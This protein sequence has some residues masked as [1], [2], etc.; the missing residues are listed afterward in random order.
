MSNELDVSCREKPASKLNK[1]DLI[2]LSYVLVK[3]SEGLETTFNA[4]VIGAT[5]YSEIIWIV[6]V[7]QSDITSSAMD[8]M[9]NKYG[10]INCFEKWHWYIG[11][12]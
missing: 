9:L 6:Y 11:E 3:C 5:S 10:E 7:A 2:W 4:F 8:V 12:L 1:N